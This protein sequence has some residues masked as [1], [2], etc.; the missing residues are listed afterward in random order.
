MDSCFLAPSAP[1]IT[2]VHCPGPS[3]EGPCVSSL[4]A[5]FLL[6]QSISDFPPAEEEQQRRMECVCV[7]VLK[8]FKGRVRGSS[9]AGTIW[10][11]TPP[12]APS[13]EPACIDGQHLSTQ[14][15]KP[16]HSA[17][18]PSLNWTGRSFL[19]NICCERRA[20]RKEEAAFLISGM[21]CASGP[22]PND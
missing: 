20:Q 6:S 17:S 22:I 13:P 15:V 5:H 9:L 11:T 16:G 8:G 18:D 12:R 7:C 10:R 4:Q 3:S 21:T 2:A 19:H 1:G 14:Q